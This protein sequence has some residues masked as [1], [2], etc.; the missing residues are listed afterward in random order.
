VIF[1]QDL[2]REIFDF[3]KV[4]QAKVAIFRI[5]AQRSTIRLLLKDGLTTMEIPWR[6]NQASGTNVKK[7]TQVFS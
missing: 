4:D 7:K 5:L 2:A 3:P 1:C 6:P